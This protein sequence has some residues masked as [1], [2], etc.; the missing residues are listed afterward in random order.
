MTL[1]VHDDEGTPY[2]QTID[3]RET[4]HRTEIQYNN[5]RRGKRK[6]TDTATNGDV[7][8]PGDDHV[9]LS[10]GDVLTSPDDIRKWSLSSW[11]IDDEVKILDSP[12][13]WLRIDADMEWICEISLGMPE[14]MYAA[15]LQQDRDV[16]AQY[17]VRPSPL[18]TLV[19][20]ILWVYQRVGY[21]SYHHDTNIDGSEILLR[22][23]ARSCVYFS[24]GNRKS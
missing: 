10:F 18:L 13:A 8:I 21:N 20:E 23:P 3:I 24:Q 22:Y 16:V 4:V 15:Q 17:E 11:S 5:S 12:F 6:R 14:F 1:R 2:D 7:L 9:V 19:Y